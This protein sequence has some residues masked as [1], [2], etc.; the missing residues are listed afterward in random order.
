M[1]P[2]TENGAVI[3]ELDEVEMCEAIIAY[4]M[5]RIENGRLQV[6][7][8]GH[9]DAVTLGA[10]VTPDRRMLALIKGAI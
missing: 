2:E 4:C 3:L 9:G 5:M 10:R 6:P 7:G 8:I 1:L